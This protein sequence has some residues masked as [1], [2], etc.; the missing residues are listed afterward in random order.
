MGTLDTSKN[1]VMY[2]IDLWDTPN[3]T[4][5]A[6]KNAG[7]KVICY[8]SAGSYEDWRQDKSRFPASVKGNPLDGWNGESWLDV[9][10]LDIL[11]PIMT[12]RLDLAKAKRCDGV[13]PDNVD[14]YTQINGG[15][16]KV[17][18]Q[19]QIIY[20]TWLAREA[21]ARDLS[22]GLKNDLD[23]VPDLVSHF[24]WAINEQCFVY[25]EC[26]TLQ[27]FIKANKA[28]FNCEYATHRNCLKAV[29][30]KMSSIQAT[31]ALDGKNMKMCNAQGQLLRHTKRRNQPPT[32]QISRDQQSPSGRNCSDCKKKPPQVQCLHCSQHVCL[33]CAQKHVNLVAGDTEGAIHLLNEKIDV[34]DRIAANTRQN[35]VTARDNI[36]KK[37]DAERDQ[38]FALLTQ[39]IEQEKQQLRNKNKQLN[40]LPLNEIAMFIRRL[41][42]DLQ[43]LNE[44]DNSLF[45]IITTEP[46]IQL[47]RQRQQLFIENDD[48]DYDPRCD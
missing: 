38:A 47:Q 44:K 22:I 3:N 20:N 34:L 21:H 2:D 26:D 9:R 4:I 33:E 27:P 30:S 28:V 32:V 1:V 24:D 48:D 7:K 46:R 19:D 14:V 43:Y 12:A 8:F 35:I 17:T 39:M 45:N 31:L 29:Q 42:S 41:P 37:A 13:E 25:N 16:F 23:Q 6:L 11:G 36:V 5:T 15:G 40:E 18:Y 10:R